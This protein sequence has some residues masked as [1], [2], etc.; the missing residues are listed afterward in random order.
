[1]I[2]YYRYFVTAVFILLFFMTNCKTQA[3]SRDS[4]DW[5]PVIR[6]L[7]MISFSGLPDS[8]KQREIK[9]VFESH[10]IA[11]EDYQKFY[12]EM[13]EEDPQNS[14][15]VLKSV[16]QLISEDMKT[17]AN[18]QRKKADENRKIK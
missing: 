12:S 4:I 14:L 15:P 13:T 2:R 7:Q 1:M 17:D 11:L 8:V 10:Q 3:P 18:I 16:E 5:A 6:D 9:K